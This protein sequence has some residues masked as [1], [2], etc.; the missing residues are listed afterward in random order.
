MSSVLGFLQNVGEFL[1]GLLGGWDA[2]LK[3]LI[4]MMALDYISG[5][6]VGF[7]GRSPNSPTGGID[8]RAGFSGLLKKGLILMVIAVSAQI[9]STV[10]GAFV[11][12]AT[13]WFYIVNEGIS[14]LENAVLAGVPLPEKLVKLLDVGQEAQ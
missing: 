9:D 5:M 11:R 2:T 13:T 1:L 14:V 10:D 4:A 7:M 6:I 3:L 8:S 12:A